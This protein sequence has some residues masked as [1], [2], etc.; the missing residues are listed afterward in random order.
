MLEERSHQKLLKLNIYN[1]ESK[2]F[3]HRTDD[4]PFIQLS[5]A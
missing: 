4:P 3:L 5:N 1:T 2:K